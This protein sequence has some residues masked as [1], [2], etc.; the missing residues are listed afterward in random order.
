MFCCRFGRIEVF[1]PIPP[2]DGKSPN[3]PHT[4]VLPRLLAQGQT[5][6]ANV[7]LPQG[8]VPCMTLFP[9]NPIPAIS[10]ARKPFDSAQFEA[11]QLLWR[12]YGEPDLVAL[13]KAALAALLVGKEPELRDDTVSTRAARSVVRVAARQA[14][15]LIAMSSGCGAENVSA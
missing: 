7:P 12:R 3:G 11:F 8:W 9:P 10:S 2:P 13:K 4:H 5:Y 15:H 6:A 14:L 1:A